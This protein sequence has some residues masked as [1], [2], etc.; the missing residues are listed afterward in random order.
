MTE[1]SSCNVACYGYV[2]HFHHSNMF[3]TEFFGVLQVILKFIFCVTEKKVLQSVN[4]SLS[5]YMCFV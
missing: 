5:S 2:R 4:G 3:Q 1:L